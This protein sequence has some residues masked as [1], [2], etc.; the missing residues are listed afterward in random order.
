MQVKSTHNPT[1]LTWGYDSG[2]FNAP[3]SPDSV[4]HATLYSPTRDIGSLRDEMTNAANILK[5]LVG[6]DEIILCFSGGMDSQMAA[7]ALR[8]AGAKFKLVHANVYLGEYHINH[9]ESETCIAFS[10]KF[11]FPMEVIDVDLKKCTDEYIDLVNGHRFVHFIRFLYLEIAKLY[12]NNLVL[13]AGGGETHYNDIL[14]EN[15]QFTDSFLDIFDDLHYYGK[16]LGVNAL[17]TFYKTDQHLFFKMICN[18]HFLKFNSTWP[19]FKDE[20]ATHIS[21]SATNWQLSAIYGSV[22][23]Q[24]IARD[25]YGDELFYVKKT[26]PDENYPN[27][28]YSWKSYWVERAKFNRYVVDP[29]VPFNKIIELS[30]MRNVKR[31][32]TF[33]GGGGEEGINATT[34]VD[35]PC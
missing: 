23:K 15:N 21:K 25:T 34:I 28:Y 18:E 4:L 3:T 6:N 8:D 33:H 35:S 27:I 17:Y 9:N 14:S 22:I 11:N 10:K 32:F 16:V 20:V 24:I 1:C 2:L 13:A 19:V 29:V 12:P 30:S 26:F 31:T 7:L 5:E